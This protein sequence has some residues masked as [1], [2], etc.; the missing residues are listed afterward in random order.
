[1]CIFT[2]GRTPRAREGQRPI[3]STRS[4]RFGADSAHVAAELPVVPLPAMPWSTHWGEWDA[5]T[6]PAA[7]GSTTVPDYNET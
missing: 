4:S 7:D 2:E 5:D 6:K 1:M 3:R